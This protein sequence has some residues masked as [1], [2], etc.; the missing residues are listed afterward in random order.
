MI[1][2]DDTS[3]TFNFGLLRKSDCK[4]DNHVE[5]VYV[6]SER[7]GSELRQE[8]GS[9]DHSENSDPG[10]CLLSSWC[11][12]F[13]V[14][15]D[16]EFLKFCFRNDNGNCIITRTHTEKKFIVLTTSMYWYIIGGKFRVSLFNL[17]SMCKLLLHIKQEYIIPVCREFTKVLFY[18][19]RL[20]LSGTW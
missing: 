1:K 16:I 19:S 7:W 12:G 14:K 15:E 11:V 9:A 5:W 2:K 6:H 17:H 13:L 3:K 20:D 18:L 10:A 8:T 4:N